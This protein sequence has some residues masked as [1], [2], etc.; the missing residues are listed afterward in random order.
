MPRFKLGATNL[1]IVGVGS[2]RELPRLVGRMLMHQAVFV[3]LPDE[4]GTDGLIAAA[5]TLR[6]VDLADLLAGGRI[7]LAAQDGPGSLADLLERHIGFAPPAEILRWP[8]QDSE[9]FANHAA[10]LDRIMRSR[11]ESTQRR[12]EALARRYAE[13]EQIGTG[14]PGRSRAVLGFAPAAEWPCD[15]RLKDWLRRRNSAKPISWADRT[16]RRP[17]HRPRPSPTLLRT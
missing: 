10:R 14:Q 16:G 7:V 1:A 12:T 9:Q 6:L 5:A 2:G 11:T 8:W 13:I 4:Q 17:P 15:W 3:L